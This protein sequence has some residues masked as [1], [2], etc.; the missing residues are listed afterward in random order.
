MKKLLL[1][2]SMIFPFPSILEQ[3]S[4]RQWAFIREGCCLETLKF[5]VFYKGVFIC[6]R[7]S[8]RSSGVSISTDGLRNMSAT[9]LIDVGHFFTERRSILL[10][11]AKGPLVLR[12]A[13]V[14]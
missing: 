6:D 11:F 13:L 1:I 5:Y 7:V 2:N 4:I 14:M 9:L 10:C 8:I 12:Y 3:L